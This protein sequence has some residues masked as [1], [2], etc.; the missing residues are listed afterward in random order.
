MQ[1]LLTKEQVAERLSVSERTVDRLRSRGLLTSVKFMSR[2]R[3]RLEDVEALLRAHRRAS[4]RPTTEGQ[5]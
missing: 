1:S 5:A 4:T 3:F 2:V